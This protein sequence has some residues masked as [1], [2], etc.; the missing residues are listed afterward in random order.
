MPV[1]V[2]G[3]HP[4]RHRA[5]LRQRVFHF[6]AHHGVQVIVR[7][8]TQEIADQL[9]GFQPVKVVGVDNGKGRL[10]VVF[11]AEHGMARSPR[12]CAF[13]RAKYFLKIVAQFFTNDEHDL[14]EPGPDG[15]EKRIVDD[16][17]AVWAELVELF[18]TTVTSAHASR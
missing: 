3:A 11:G 16:G 9:K 13:H 1:G 8:G 15:V 5:V 2:N 17:F 14:A 6:V 7:I 4:P 12:L 18:D 10:R